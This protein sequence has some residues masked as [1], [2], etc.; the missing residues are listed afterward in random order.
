M[1]SG[2]SAEESN[3]EG[4]TK[5]DK[6]KNLGDS[7]VQPALMQDYLSTVKNA[8]TEFVRKLRIPFYHKQAIE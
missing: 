5:V 7:L 1:M 3:S 8:V 4:V 2:I 6:A